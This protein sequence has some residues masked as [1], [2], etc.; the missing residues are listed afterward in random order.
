MKKLLIILV[1][2]AA[3]ANAQS[4]Q[5]TANESPVRFWGSFDGVPAD[6]LKTARDLG[7]EPAVIT[8]ENNG[9]LSAGLGSRMDGNEAITPQIDELKERMRNDKGIMSLISALQNDPEMLA[10]LNDPAIMSAV[11]SGDLGALTNSPAFMKLLDNPRV[12]EIEKS[13]EPGVTRQ[14]TPTR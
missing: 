11:Q 10:L 3:T 1:L 14:L 4:Y 6:Y 8:A 2:T 12:R 5:S 13:L 9:D 7:V